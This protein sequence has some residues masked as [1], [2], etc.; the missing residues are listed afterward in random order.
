MDV[1]T[2]GRGFLFHARAGTSG[3]ASASGWPLESSVGM[4]RL[5]QNERNALLVRISVHRNDYR[6]KY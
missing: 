6:T 4:F 3:I 1:A 5:G 2:V